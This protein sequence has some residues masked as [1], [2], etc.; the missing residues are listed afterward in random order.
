LCRDTLE[1]EAAEA[2]ESTTL[3]RLCDALNHRAADLRLAL[4]RFPDKGEWERICNAPPVAGAVADLQAALGDLGA[5]LEP[6]VSRGKELGLCERRLKALGDTLDEF[7]A[8]A[9]DRVSWYEIDAQNFRLAVSPLE[10][11]E[12]FRQ[13][14]EQAD[15]G[16][17]F[18]TSATLSTQ[19]SF[20]FYCRRLGLEGIACASF[21]SPFDYRRQ[22]L[23]YLPDNLPDPAD[24]AYAPRFGELCH[25]LIQAA[26]GHCFILFTSYRMLT[27]T[28]DYLRGR[29]DH[30]L[31]VQGELQ[32]NE[33]LQQFLALSNPVLLGTSSFWEGVDVKGDQL[34]CVI[35]D[36]LPFRSPSDPVYR[37]RLQRVKENGGNAFTEIQVPEAT[38]SLR[39]GVGR[40]IRDAGDRGVVA[41]CDNR[42]H[43][44]S[45]GRGML[46]SLPPMPRSSNLDEVRAFLRE[47]SNSR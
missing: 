30:P 46:D 21:E 1:A 40:L 22:A 38:I 2:A 26:E 25:E 16:S 42:L 17:I 37:R 7:L 6:M 43:T 45:Y 39:Q 33:L 5:A 28:A 11:A 34:R 29:I 14:L 4:G 3:G 47:L 13:Q 19:H 32:R 35:I 31:L 27:W 44:R 10:V 18:F 20:D 8:P 23:L 36:K 12:A 24:D 15:F 41:I 9:D